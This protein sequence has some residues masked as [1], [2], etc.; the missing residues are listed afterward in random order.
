MLFFA[1]TCR[2]PREKTLKGK[3]KCKHPLTARKSEEKRSVEAVKVFC[4][5]TTRPKGGVE[6]VTKTRS[7]RPLLTHFIAVIFVNIFLSYYATPVFL[8]FQYINCIYIRG[9]WSGV[10]AGEAGLNRIVK[11]ALS[12]RG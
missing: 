3:R 8:Y 10:G 9:G 1:S 4:Q 12:Q 7:A 11:T 2:F 5:N 6:I